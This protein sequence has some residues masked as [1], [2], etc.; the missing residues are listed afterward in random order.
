MV[1]SSCL[2]PV[3]MVCL[4][5]SSATKAHLV[6]KPVAVSSL[7]AAD[8][9]QMCR[10]DDAAKLQMDPCNAYIVGAVDGLSITGVICINSPESFTLMATGIVRKFVRE[11]PERWKGPAIGLVISALLPKF[12]CRGSS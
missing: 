1:K 2:V 9:V 7:T 5:A 11:N 8:L 3:A 10:Y 6:T 12:A 4:L